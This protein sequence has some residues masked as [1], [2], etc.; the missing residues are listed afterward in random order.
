MKVGRAQ[1]VVYLFAV[2]WF[3][4]GYSN[5]M[6][7]V[8]GQETPLKS[9]AIGNEQVAESNGKVQPQATTEILAAVASYMQA[10]NQR[11]LQ[12]LQDLWTEDGIYTHGTTGDRVRG[13][14][15][16]A[17][18]IAEIFESQDNPHLALSSDT[19]ELISPGVA[20]ERGMA[21]VTRGQQTSESRYSVVYVNRDGKW[22]IDRVTEED[23]PSVAPSHHD[24]LRVL[25]W[26][27][28][29]WSDRSDHSHLEMS[30]DWTS[31]Q[32]YLSRTFKLTHEDGS[33]SSG[34]QLIGWDA[35]RE[36]IR[37]WLFDSDGGFV[38]GIWEQRDQV[39]VVSAVA[40]LADGSSGSFTSLLRPLEEGAYAWQK[41]N[42]VHDGR[43][44]PNLEE[45]IVRRR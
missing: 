8:V 32:N 34:L 41:I 9:E 16:I 31:K 33:V 29:D 37:S 7:S 1:A 19:V 24:H 18:Q 45:V 30:C 3:A 42:R 44:L 11:D 4:V 13:R 38:S 5:C 25:E 23:L 12:T 20:L 22:L 14:K 15:M 2:G 27:I 6:P 36:E 39:W 10:F 26:M 28:G 43:L 40:T 21:V 17:D 35:K